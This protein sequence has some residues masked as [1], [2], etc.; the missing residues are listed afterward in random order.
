MDCH[1][2]PF[3]AD[4]PLLKIWEVETPW[5]YIDGDNEGKIE[6]FGLKVKYVH[7]EQKPKGYVLSLEL[8]NITDGDA[9][10]WAT[11]WLLWR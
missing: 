8:A 5:N 10:K 6:A 11:R 4:E 7:G 1:N 9:E 3:Y 2:F